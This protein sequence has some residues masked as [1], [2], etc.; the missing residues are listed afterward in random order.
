MVRESLVGLLAMG[1]GVCCGFSGW[2]SVPPPVSLVYL[3]FI[4]GKSHSSGHA[5]EAHSL[6]ST[7]HRL[8]KGAGRG[9]EAGQ[10]SSPNFAP[11]WGPFNLDVTVGSN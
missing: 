11:A 1:E 10:Q 8:E 3:L 4:L 7:V 2:P 5:G 9:R 6:P